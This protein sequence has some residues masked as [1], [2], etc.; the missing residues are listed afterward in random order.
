MSPPPGFTGGHK[1]SL[2]LCT[3]RYARATAQIHEGSQR[4]R[5][6]QC[7]EYP[8]VGGG[9][10]RDSGQPGQRTLRG[11][12]EERDGEEALGRQSRGGRRGMWK[13]SCVRLSCLFTNQARNNHGIFLGLNLCGRPRAGRINYPKPCA[14][15]K[16][17]EKLGHRIKTRWR[18]GMSSSRSTGKT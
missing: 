17:A 16:E 5:R 13:V 12:R 14:V 8:L 4:G 10:R 11:E 7:S 9:E 15:V 1:A 6:V 2:E 3:L 18:K